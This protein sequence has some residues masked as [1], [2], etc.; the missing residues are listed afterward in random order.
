MYVPWKTPGRKADFQLA[1]SATG[2]PGH[3]AMNPGRL[4]FSV[5]IP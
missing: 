4:A 3:I 5:P 2:S 1:T